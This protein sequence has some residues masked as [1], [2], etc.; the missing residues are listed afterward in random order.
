MS[1]L[2]LARKSSSAMSMKSLENC[3]MVWKFLNTKKVMEKSGNF[4][5]L[6]FAVA[7]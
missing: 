2:F 6:A 5:I 4:M 1:S 3:K 7:F